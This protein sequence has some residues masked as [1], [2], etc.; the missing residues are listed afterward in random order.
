MDT[1]LGPYQAGYKKAGF[2]LDPSSD[3]GLD[4][5]KTSTDHKRR[6]EAYRSPAESELLAHFKL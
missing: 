2:V 4:P 6:K 3:F 1:K 5:Y